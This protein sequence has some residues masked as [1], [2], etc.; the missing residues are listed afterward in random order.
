[1][2]AEDIRF[3]LPVSNVH[4]AR[5]GIFALAAGGIM[6]FQHEHQPFK[7]WANCP[8]YWIL[9]FFVQAIRPFWWICPNR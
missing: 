2:E 7:R 1:M 6:P 4:V 9:T 3:G 8:S 5:A